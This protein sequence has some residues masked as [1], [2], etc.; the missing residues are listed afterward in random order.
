[1]TSGDK[2]QTIFNSAV[3]QLESIREQ[4]DEATYYSKRCMFKGL[5]L[6]YLNLWRTSILAVTR[7][8]FPKF[9]KQE[10]KDVIELLKK[11]GEIKGVVTITKTPEGNYKTIN[12]K[13]FTKK[14]I[15]LHKLDS[16]VRQYADDHGLFNPNRR[17]DDSPMDA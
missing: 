10:K 12:Q 6:E 17:S 16:K 14:W 8:V 4:L 15:K 5:H 7:E 13:K 1:M 11:V 2:V 9:N 3:A